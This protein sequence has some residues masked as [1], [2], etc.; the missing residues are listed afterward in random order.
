MAELEAM[1]STTFNTAMITP[2]DTSHMCRRTVS[3]SVSTSHAARD[4]AATAAPPLRMSTSNWLNAR[5]ATAAD[6]GTSSQTSQPHS[7]LRFT[8][9]ALACSETCRAQRARS[10]ATGAAAAAGG[11]I[12]SSKAR[13]AIGM[14]PDRVGSA[15]RGVARFVT[16]SARRYSR[17]SGTTSLLGDITTAHTHWSGWVVGVCTVAVATV[18]PFTEKVTLTVDI[19]APVTSTPTTSP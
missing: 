8:G 10:W 12:A 11:W 15:E 2:G 4:T 18:R 3:S 14:P 16:A 7:A 17:A 1:A 19:E 13:S 9:T 5:S 6:R